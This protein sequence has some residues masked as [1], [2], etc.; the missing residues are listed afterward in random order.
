MHD[1]ILMILNPENYAELYGLRY[2][3]SCLWVYI[4]LKLCHFVLVPSL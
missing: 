4:L 2:L 1:T 3:S